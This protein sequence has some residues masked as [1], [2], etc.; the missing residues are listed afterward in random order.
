MRSSGHA[1][2]RLDERERGPAGIRAAELLACHS[3]EVVELGI[4]HHVEE[5]PLER[6]AEAERQSEVR[7]PGR[8]DEAVAHDV[9][10]EA[11][12]A[13]CGGVH[14]TGVEVA[15]GPCKR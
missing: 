7:M 2:E 4:G 3:A 9:D 10:V 15:A 1:C 11:R 8:Q 13:G 12:S 6:H 5:V 14:V